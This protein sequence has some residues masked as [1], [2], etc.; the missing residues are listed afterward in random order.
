MVAGH[1]EANT[2]FGLGQESF[3]L[4]IV[5]KTNEDVAKVEFILNSRGRESLGFKSSNQVMFE[6]LMVA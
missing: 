1:F 4:T 6:H 2:I 3:L 5:D